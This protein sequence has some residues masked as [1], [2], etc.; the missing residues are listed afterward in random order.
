M[1]SGK[2]VQARTLLTTTMRWRKTMF[3]YQAAR[4][5][6][7][8]QKSERGAGV[9]EWLAISALS[10]GLIVGINEAFDGIVQQLITRIQGLLGL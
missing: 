1:P 2:Q 7:N 5:S 6:S 8:K 10:V 4:V 3:M 9:V